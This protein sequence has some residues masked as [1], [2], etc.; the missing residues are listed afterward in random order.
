MFT[1]VPLAL[2]PS[3]VHSQYSCT[4]QPCACAPSGSQGFL[5]SLSFSSAPHPS[6]WDYAVISYSFPKLLKR[7]IATGIL[8]PLRLPV[9]FRGNQ[10]LYP[11]KH[12]YKFYR[13][14]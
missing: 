12:V 13:L 9:G 8:R 6:K 4:Q 14:D 11:L 5:I 10:K 1:R 7:L 2:C 3:A